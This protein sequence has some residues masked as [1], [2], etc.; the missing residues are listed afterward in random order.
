MLSPNARAGS[1]G[2][3][4]GEEGAAPCLTPSRPV[5]TQPDVIF[6]GYTYALRPTQ[7][8]N[9]QLAQAA[10]VCRLVWNLALEQRRNH[11]RNYRAR[12][13]NHLNFVA[14]CRE[15]TE[16]RAE[17]D[18]IR[19]VSQT[20][21]QR[22]LKA[23]DEACNR[24]RQGLAGYPKP[25][26]KGVHDAFSFAGREIR[27]EK[28]N[29]RWARVRLPKIGWIK[30]R[31]SRAIGGS[32][33]EATVTRT[34][35]GWQ[36]SI[37][38]MLDAGPADNGRTVGVDRG[39]AVPL[40]LS[41]G[42]PYR[43]APEIARLERLVREAQRIAGR[44]KRGSRRWARAQQRVA[45]LK[46]RQAR[47]RQHW[48]HETTTD[49]T[50]RYGGVVVERLRTGNMTRSG[51]GT[52][53]APGANVRQKAGLNRAILNVGWHR[54]ETMLA[55]KAVRFV[56]VDPSYTS[57]TCASCGTA[58]GRSRESQAVFVCTACGHRDNAD[59][60]AAVNILNRGNT[61]GV[62]PGRWAGD[63]ARTVQA[64]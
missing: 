13:G 46:A 30:L 9:E 55:Y 53:D 49:I 35:L 29:G 36:V 48:A 60:N 7:E 34:A 20:A 10:G 14:Q 45:G 25:K 64:A 31:Y 8:Q 22:T 61:P 5:P 54:I 1:P 62:E 58:D 39:V 15:L 17:F 59:R 16:L 63:E 52:P 3:Q 11:W 42:T 2:I 41:D 12:T 26:K 44:R 50:R 23:L 56:R 18:F 43:L 19:A 38:C 37:G 47:A 27:L 24:A 33:R 40:M 28:L 6:R 4:A 51:R 57:Q 32:I 21:Q